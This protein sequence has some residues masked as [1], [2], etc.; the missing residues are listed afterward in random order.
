MLCR[1]VRTS[2]H[3]GLI[4]VMSRSKCHKL[5]SAAPLK[6][7]K[8]GL[9]GALVYVNIFPHCSVTLVPTGEALD[10]VTEIRCDNF[11]IQSEHDA[12]FK[13]ASVGPAFSSAN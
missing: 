12:F 6:G 3:R 4:Q 10:C 1:V 13:S 8:Q 7:F 9:H 5:H 11:N 2:G